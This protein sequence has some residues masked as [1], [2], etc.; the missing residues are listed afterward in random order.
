MIRKVYEAWRALSDDDLREKR[1]RRS[2]SMALTTE[3]AFAPPKH[4]YGVWRYFSL[5][6]LELGSGCYSHGVG[7]GQGDC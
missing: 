1:M 3:G 5:L 4:V 7:R 2:K 6:Q